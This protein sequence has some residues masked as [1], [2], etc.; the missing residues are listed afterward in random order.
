[1]EESEVCKEQQ[2][3]KKIIN[4]LVFVENESEDLWDPSDGVLNVEEN[5]K[6]LNL[7]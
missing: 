6:K 4:I 2:F 3:E 7:N 1:M 5:L